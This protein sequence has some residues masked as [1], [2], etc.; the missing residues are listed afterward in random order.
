MQVFVSYAVYNKKT[1]ETRIKNE[2]VNLDIK[3]MS[4]FDLNRIKKIEH[5]LE[6]FESDLDTEYEIN[7]INYKAM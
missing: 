1:K 6:I 5:D 2:V 3:D 7:I 4:E